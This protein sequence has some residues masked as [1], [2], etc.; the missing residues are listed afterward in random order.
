MY[1]KEFG[2]PKTG[3]NSLCSVAGEGEREKWSEQVSDS[4]IH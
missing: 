4:S 2:C 1:G 3:Y